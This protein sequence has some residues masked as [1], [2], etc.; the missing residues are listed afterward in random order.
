MS[1]FENRPEPNWVD[2]FQKK[3]EFE[4]LVVGDD[5][6]Y[7]IG[8]M[9]DEIEDSVQVVSIEIDSGEAA[10]FIKFNPVTKELVVN[11]T[12]IGDSDVGHWALNI[13]TTFKDVDGK[14]VQ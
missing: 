10:K 3:L 14:E 4:D 1:N 9:I 2:Q 8:G 6:K 12:K 5:Y 7:S 11:S 13:T